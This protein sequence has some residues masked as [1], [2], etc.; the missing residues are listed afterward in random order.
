VRPETVGVPNELEVIIGECGQ[1]TQSV[2][3]LT[4]SLIAQVVVVAADDLNAL[5]SV[6]GQLHSL[7]AL[8]DETIQSIRGMREL[9]VR[10]EKLVERIILHEVQDANQA[11]AE[12]GKGI[13]PACGSARGPPLRGANAQ[14]G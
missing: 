5:A 3:A 14:P 6:H 13:R 8:P 4:E 11:L 7:A 2:I 9:A 10:L 12:L 1:A